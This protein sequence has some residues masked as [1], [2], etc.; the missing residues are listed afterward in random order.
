VSQFRL[1]CNDAEGN[2]VFHGILNSS[3][4]DSYSIEEQ[5]I[6]FDTAQNFNI[7]SSSSGF[8]D[9]VA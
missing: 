4:E 2:D 3:I 8:K 1:K 5:F 9:A 6:I 7:K